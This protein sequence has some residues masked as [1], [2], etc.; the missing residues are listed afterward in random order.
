MITHGYAT[1][2]K[3]E[4]VETWTEENNEVLQ[5]TKFEKWAKSN[6]KPKVYMK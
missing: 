3:D 4:A 2:K 6:P 5:L 1:V